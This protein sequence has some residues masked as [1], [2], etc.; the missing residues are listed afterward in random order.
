M[1]LNSPVARAGLKRASMDQNI[2]CQSSNYQVC[3][4][5]SQYTVVF[6]DLWLDVTLHDVNS[7]PL[8]GVHGKWVFLC[9]T[10]A[11][12]HI[13]SAGELQITANTLAINL[14]FVTLWGYFWQLCFG[15]VEYKIL[16]L[17]LQIWN[18]V[19]KIL[20]ALYCFLSPLNKLFLLGDNFT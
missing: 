4:Y 17:F 15:G 9:T 5:T 20:Y 19:V 13:F 18:H 12:K 7:F 10:K 14:R 16:F 1:N 3:Y 2:V 8:I 11:M 6:T